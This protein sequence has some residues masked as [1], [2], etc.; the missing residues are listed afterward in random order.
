MLKPIISRLALGLGALFGLLAGI[1][2]PPVSAAG[3]VSLRVEP[4]FDG[5][6]K[7]REW[8]GLDVEVVNDGQAR[9]EGEVAYES[10]DLGR[11][12][13]EFSAPVRLGPGE[14]GRYI[15]PV[16]MTGFERSGVVRLRSGGRTV[17]ED[18]VTLFPL[19]ANDFLV[20]VAGRDPLPLHFKFSL[21]PQGQS[22]TFVVS[23]R[24]DT[25][26]DASHLLRSFDALILN[27]LP[28]SRLAPAQTQ[29]LTDWVLG[30]GHLVVGGLVSAEDLEGFGSL[31][32]VRVLG[33]QTVSGLPNLERTIQ[34][35]IRAWE[36]FEVTA[37][38]PAA[39]AQ[40]LVAEEGLPLIVRRRFGQGTVTF[41]AMDG[42]AAPLNA[43]WGLGPM[44]RLV[45]AAE[46]SPTEEFQSRVK[47]TNLGAIYN[48]LAEQVTPFDLPSAQ[49]VVLFL[50][51]YVI[52]V[53]PINFLVL[54]RLR[55][56]DW[57]WFTTPVITFLFGL[58]VFGL[59]FSPQAQ[60]VALRDVTIVRHPEDLRVGYAD[61]YIAVFSPV[62]RAYDLEFPA[63]VFPSP[64]LPFWEWTNP[65]DSQP[66]TVETD[67]RV[68]R[69][70]NLSVDAWG[71]RGV[72]AEGLIRYER[73]PLQ[74]EVVAEP[75][76]VRLRV[77]NPG[78][79]SVDGLVAWHSAGIETVGR[80][81]P[82]EVREVF[83]R[84]GPVGGLEDLRLQQ[85]LLTGHKELPEQLLN[86]RR[87]VLSTLF[88][89]EITTGEPWRVGGVRLIAWE[90]RSPVAVQ[91][92]GTPSRQSS[93]ILRFIR[94]QPRTGPG[95]RMV[96]PGTMRRQLTDRDAVY[97]GPS[98][99]GFAVGGGSVTWRYYL[100]A[101]FPAGQAVRIDLLF[102]A[103][104]RRPTDIWPRIEAFNF[105]Q[106]RWVDLE[107]IG[108]KV[109]AA[110]GAEPQAWP[111][112]TLVLP[113]PA[114]EFIAPAGYL[115]LK[116]VAPAENI[117]EVLVLEP[118]IFA[119]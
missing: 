99:F 36:P 114:A 35:P 2:A 3:P 103:Q 85:L 64:L 115:D 39:E 25:L 73:E 81:G 45:L 41:M 17:A 13:T 11:R 49:V 48:A 27:A 7:L 5:Y 32:P 51:A 101:D 83:I 96:A 113:D 9:F 68:R 8:T 106:S 19:D 15:V 54:R 31:I 98:A 55:R 104:P 63:S 67:G 119:E 1:L 74:V 100:P 29:A 108:E 82:G 79:G 94:L 58:V 44:W 105:R 40:V 69:L 84:A 33:R 107:D 38:A 28:A 80:L 118:R 109:R 20:G 26:P 12:V 112:V 4:L 66:V 93:T 70:K 72:L 88:D 42:S 60:G 76:G 24:P 86:V 59:G 23:L 21:R 75:E 62:Y 89:D 14:R 10:V 65:P 47:L 53:G 90:D 34:V 92:S 22:R 95:L 30:G 16:M 52:M 50:G 102:N 43:W 111:Q 97:L 56:P 37:V 18:Q 91:V 57:F 6:Y 87:L 46:R 117:F 77:A 78:P 71:L 116:V 110:A 61:S